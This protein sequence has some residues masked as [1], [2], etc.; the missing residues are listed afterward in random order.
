[1]KQRVASNTMHVDSGLTKE[2]VKIRKL[3][4]RIHQLTA[5]INKIK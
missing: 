5:K 4:I 2:Q 1:M 3:M